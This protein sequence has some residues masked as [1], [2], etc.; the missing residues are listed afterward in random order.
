MGVIKQQTIKGTFY[1]YAGIL[2]G[3]ITTVILLPQL[4]SEEQIGLTGILTSLSMLFGQFS[5]L[6]FAGTARY[7]P[8]FRNQ[9]KGHHGYLFLFCIVAVV[10]TAIMLL[11][12]IVFKDQII[13]S[14]SQKSDLFSSYYWYLIPLIVF[15]AFFNVF[16]RYAMMLYN[17]S[18]GRILREFTKR[19]FILIPVVLLCFKL[20]SFNIFMILWLIANILPTALMLRRLVQDGH[21]F[22]KPDF[23][24]LDRDMRKKLI[25]ISV[26]GLLVGSSPVIIESIDKYIINSHF[27]LDDT[28]IYTISFYFATIVSLP[29]RSLYSIAYTVVAEAWKENDLKTIKDIYAK[30]CIVQIVTALFLVILIWANIHNIFHIL[31]GKYESGKYVIFF[32][33][34]AN[35]IDSA[36]G[37]NTAVLASSKYYRY[38]GYFTLSLAILTIITNILLTP[39]FGITGSAIATV[40]TVLTINLFRY[41]F[42]LFA[43]KMQPFTLKSPLAIL[44]GVGIYYLSVAIIPK[45]D[46]FISDIILRSSFIAILYISAVY[47]LKLSDDINKTIDSYLAKLKGLIKT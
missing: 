25:Q 31:P 46:Y 33:C 21:F 5:G 24:F 43:F 11:F 30:S 13:S 15:T 41:M 39:R 18:S 9:E 8:Y 37:I 27:G 14:K 42:L 4:L 35:L 12:A 45:F 34:L 7:F 22:F 17:T 10:G 29:S 26:F 23:K 3:F 28:G 44:L 38:D 16:E 36:T 20:I 6:G 2:I 40:I 32:I 1:S 47:F 19:I